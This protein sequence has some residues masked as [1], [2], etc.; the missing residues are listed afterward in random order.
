MPRLH[1]VNVPVCIVESFAGKASS[2]AV[3]LPHHWRSDMRDYLIQASNRGTALSNSKL[4][5]L[6]DIYRMW[7]F[8]RYTGYQQF[9]RRG[10]TK[11]EVYKLYSLKRKFRVSLIVNKDLIVNKE[12]NDVPGP[13]C[14]Q[15]NMN[16]LEKT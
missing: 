6:L 14:S 10:R 16:R 13:T 1:V 9:R 15:A 7:A 11:G 5:M 12:I 4:G 8:W 3:L 2:L